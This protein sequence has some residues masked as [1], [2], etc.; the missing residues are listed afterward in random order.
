MSASDD[1]VEIIALIL[2]R[3]ICEASPPVI[4]LIDK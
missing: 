1:F 3:K 2:L 4:D